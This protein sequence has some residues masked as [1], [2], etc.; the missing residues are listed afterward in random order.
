MGDFLETVVALYKEYR[1]VR[2]ERAGLKVV[3]DGHT[4]ALGE[5][6]STVEGAW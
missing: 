2:H 6:M 5:E 3:Q 1:A 4:G